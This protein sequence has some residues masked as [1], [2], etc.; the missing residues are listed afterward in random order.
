MQPVKPVPN[1]SISLPGNP[2]MWSISKDKQIRMATLLVSAVAHAA[3]FVQ[4][5]TLAMNS[6]AQAPKIETRISLN[7]LP[8]PKPA[9]AKPV[10]QQVIKPKPQA[11]K[12][13]VKK[14][15]LIQ[16]EYEQAVAPKLAKQVQREQPSKT[17]PARQRYLARLLTH[18]EGY[19][20]YPRSA[21]L[22]GI[23]GSIHISFRLHDNGN[24]SGL[25]ASG[26]PL[27]LR[28][29]ATGAVNKALPLPVCPPEVSCPMQV[30]YAMQF[31]LR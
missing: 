13:V 23:E 16:P 25:I 3:L 9:P 26:G 4:F 6:Q 7:L 17:I 31:Q 11:K 24:I 10:E 2:D 30:S 5:N 22:R 27:V 14:K 1:L 21:R 12:R 18:I 8:L 15:Q 28:R 19:K 20:Y 29:A